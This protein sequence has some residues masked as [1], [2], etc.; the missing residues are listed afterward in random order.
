[1][2]SAGYLMPLLTRKLKYL[3]KIKSTTIDNTAFKLHY[4]YTFNALIIACAVVTSYQFFGTPIMCLTQAK[5]VNPKTINN[6]CWVEGTFTMPKALTKITGEDV[7]MPGIEKKDRQDEIL[8]HQYYQWVCFVLFLQA[9]AFYFPHLL[10]KRWEKGQ[11]RRLVADL[12]KALLD[13]GKK[14]K[15]ATSLV[16]FLVSRKGQFNSYALGYFFC[17]ILNFVHV[18]F[19]FYITN[20]FLGGNF[21]AYGWQALFFDGSADE[22]NPL[23][24]V[25]PKMTKCNFNHYGSSGD[26][27]IYDNYCL[28][29][30]NII[31]EK[32]YI[33]FWIWLVF[34]AIVSFLTII[35]R[36]SCFYYPPARYR[37]L[38]IV[39]RRSRPQVVIDLVNQLTYGDWFVLYLLGQNIQQSHL[40]DILELLS[41]QLEQDAFNENTENEMKAISVDSKA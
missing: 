30:L 12:N 4:K 29:P 8:P 35:Y 32:I 16:Q 28:L 26:V 31:N 21:I 1:M 19:E 6:Y 2:S 36:L 40:A 22:I 5:T 27:Q 11:V 20:L 41:L 33:A 18:L 24:R 25:F 3:G 39:S 38:Q 34:L 17:E 7:V 9:L 37:L 23:T 15:S 10:W 14:T 13:D